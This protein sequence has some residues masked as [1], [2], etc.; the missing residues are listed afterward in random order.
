ML[1]N[2]TGLLL[3]GLDMSLG[4]A[5]DGSSCA[6]GGGYG[7]AG[8]LTGFGAPVTPKAASMASVSRCGGIP[9]FA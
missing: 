2:V 7:R 9:E 4:D 3:R 6:G 5:C 8:A 1:V